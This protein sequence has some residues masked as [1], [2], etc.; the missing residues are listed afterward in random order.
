MQVASN[1]LTILSYPPHSTQ[2][3]F[4]FLSYP[5]FQ[6]AKNSYIFEFEIFN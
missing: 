4:F 1:L 5:Q 3:N 6:N 2:K